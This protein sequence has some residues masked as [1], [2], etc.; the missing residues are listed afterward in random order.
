MRLSVILLLIFN[1]SC[2]KF[3][4]FPEVFTD[5]GRTLLLA[6]RG[7]GDGLH[8]ENSFAA[9]RKGLKVLDGI[10]L[11]IQVSADGTLW[12]AH[13]A[14]LPDCEL[15]KFNCFSQHTDQEIT[16]LS[17]CHG[18]DYAPGQLEDVLEIATR[19]YPDAVISLD[20]KPWFPCS[21]GDVFIHAKMK[22]LADELALLAS[23]HQLGSQIF[24]ESESVTFL[25]YIKEVSSQIECHILAFSDLEKAGLEA[26][27][28]GLDGVSYKFDPDEEIDLE[29][30]KAKGLT[31]QL[32]T[33]NT[34]ESLQKALALEPRTI[35][36]DN[37]Q[38]QEFMP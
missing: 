37:L 4:N 34:P 21:L 17:K 11:D 1:F 16:D 32:W 9:A 19:N 6:H 26:L 28:N 2:Q 18:K 13:D 38:L 33:V 22:E 10:E 3:E 29:P 24:V 27:R 35:Q 15:G 14:D 25:K 5:E 20:V 23:R 8:P 7:G 36:T 12:M 31:I 30:L